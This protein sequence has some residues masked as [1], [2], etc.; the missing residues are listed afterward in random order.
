M[1]KRD[2]KLVKQSS[3]IGVGTGMLLALTLPSIVDLN[4]ETLYILAIAF[5]V[6]GYFLQKS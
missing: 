5:V 3:L 1:K 6:A 4:T 2:Q